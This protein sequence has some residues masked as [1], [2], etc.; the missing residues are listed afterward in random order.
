MSAFLKIL[1]V[2]LAICVVA[3]LTFVF[4]YDAG[5]ATQAP[6][7]E[8]HPLAPAHFKSFESVKRSQNPSD[9]ERAYPSQDSTL[10][11]ATDPTTASLSNTIPMEAGTKSQVSDPTN[12]PVQTVAGG[13]LSPGTTA[14]S[15]GTAATNSGVVDIPMTAG[16]P[17]RE[18]TIP[19]PEGAKVPALF[20]DDVPK[21][22]PQMKALDKI[23]T[24]FEMNVSE[25]PP[26]MTKEE[27]WEAARSIADERYITLYGYQAF[28]QYHIQAAKESLKEKRARSN[29]TGP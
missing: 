8:E 24:E 5:S 12:G 7:I 19:V 28:N 6:K 20:H 25:I 13:I 26:G 9:S 4:F 18:I 29:A 1:F 15:S 16:V 14:Q 22:A 10:V 3:C 17:I 27:V 11:K 21:P 23:A 2:G